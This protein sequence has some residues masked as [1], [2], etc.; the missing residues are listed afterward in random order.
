MPWGAATAEFMFMQS[1]PDLEVSVKGVTG[2]Q[3]QLTPGAPGG[4]T[5]CD[6]E[7]RYAMGRGDSGVYVY[8]IFTRSGGLG[9]GRDG[10]AVPV[11]ARSAR[12]RDLLRHGNPLC[13]GARRQRSLCLCN[14]HS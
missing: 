14:L 11:D 10:R 4:G 5:Y 3:F 2:G 6:M 13:H 12:R 9:Q 1:L 7:I 8:A